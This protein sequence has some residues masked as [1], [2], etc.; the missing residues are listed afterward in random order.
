MIVPFRLD[1]AFAFGLASCMQVMKQ[2]MGVEKVLTSRSAFV[3]S[4]TIEVCELC[5][6][7]LS[8]CICCYASQASELPTVRSNLDILL[9]ESFTFRTVPHDLAP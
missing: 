8:V 9:H 7:S 5:E 1:W 2:Q 4:I 6:H 3:T